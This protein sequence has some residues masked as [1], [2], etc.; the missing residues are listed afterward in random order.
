M[1]TR[2]APSAPPATTDD[3][4]VMRS[5]A[6]V[7]ICFGPIIAPVRMYSAIDDDAVKFHMYHVHDDGT[8]S[9]V[10]MPCV[11]ADPECGA[12]IEQ[13]NT[14]ARGVDDPDGN[15]I[16][17]SDDEIADL[18]SD[19]GRDFNVEMFCDANDLDPIYFESPYFLEPDVSRGRSGALKSYALLRQ[20]LRDTDRVGI[21]KYA[22]RGKVHVAALRVF[23]DVLV[24]QNMV[25]T[26]QLRRPAFST[27]VEPVEIDAQELALT[28][29]F[30]ELM[31]EPFDPAKFTDNT[32]DKVRA[33]IA[34]KEAGTAPAATI[35][36]DTPTSEGPALSDLLQRLEQAVA[37][38]EAARAGDLEQAVASHPAG[39]RRSAATA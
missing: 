4:T 31:S 8:A 12:V 22:I 21:V 14:L 5:M 37:A 7:S 15:P 38:R 27:L 29:K 36:P 23:G 18:R 28:S 17:I 1:P 2:R 20:A 30:M 26:N 25:W 6:N 16:L 13:R 34:E 33:L 3:G 19:C 9:R 11:C 35:M 24:V 39:S 32:A 10:K